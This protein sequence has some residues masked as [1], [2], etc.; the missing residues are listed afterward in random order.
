MVTG[1]AAMNTSQA[2]NGELHIGDWVI[3]KPDEDYGSLIGRV[4]TIDKLGTPE[5]ETDNHGDDIHVDFTSVNYNSDEISAIE[6]N[7]ANLYGERKPYAEIPLDDVIM[8]PDM[9]ISLVGEDIA[10]TDKLTESYAAAREWANNVLNERFNALEEQLISRV[11]QNYE[12]YN[13]SLLGFGKSEIIDM[14]GVIHA[15]SDA[16]SYMTSYHVFDDDE[17]L[18]YMQFPNP[19]KIVADAWRERNADLDEMSFTMDFINE[20][21]DA[22]HKEYPLMK[23]SEPAQETEIA[24]EKPEVPQSVPKKAAGN[25][26]PPKKQSIA[27]Q[28]REGQE[29]VK[30][31]KAAKA[32]IPD[33]NK[34]REQEID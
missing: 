8:A 27:E 30:A 31:Y 15:W 12:D 10:A 1:G 22:L 20:R 9:L 33:K 34:K 14:A 21:R 18:F 7:F 17:I 4:T 11:E 26:A 5:H 19:L 3:V 13:K 25:P 16:Y 32:A 28:L 29:K 6:A 23:D 24:P 2:I